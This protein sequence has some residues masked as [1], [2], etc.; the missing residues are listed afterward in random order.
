MQPLVRA[1][2]EDLEQRR[3]RGG[4]HERV[5]VERALL[6][7]APVGDQLGELVG[8]A[9]RAAGEPAADRL[10]EADDV[11]RDAEQLGRAAGGDGRAGLDLV[12][13]Q[14]DAVLVASSRTRS[15]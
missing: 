6:A 4:H 7:H 15:R 3:L 10:G 14:H 2:R 8:H 11:G 9:D 13:D 12:E 1:G 5:A